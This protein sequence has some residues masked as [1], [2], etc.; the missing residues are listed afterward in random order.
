[1]LS[2][3]KKELSVSPVPGDSVKLGES[4]G[5]SVYVDCKSF[6]DISQSIFILLRSLTFLLQCS[7]HRSLYYQKSNGLNHHRKRTRESGL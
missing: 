2:H 5:E 4:F 6:N 1:M 3:L 7:I